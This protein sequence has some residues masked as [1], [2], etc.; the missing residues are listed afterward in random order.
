MPTPWYGEAIFQACMVWSVGAT[1]AS[2]A[3]PVSRVADALV[4]YDKLVAGSAAAGVIVKASR[5][6]VSM[7]VPKPM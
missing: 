1:Q 2:K 7:A 4:G 6:A 3:Y 5:A